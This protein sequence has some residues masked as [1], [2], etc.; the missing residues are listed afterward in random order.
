MSLVIHRNGPHCNELT[1]PRVERATLP[2]MLVHH[3]FN[4]LSMVPGMKQLKG[5]LEGSRN[6]GERRSD[7][8]ALN[9]SGIASDV[10]SG[11]ELRVRY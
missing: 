4:F 9:K 6:V 3:L 11:S 5:M 10:G 1:D 2:M 7:M 8:S